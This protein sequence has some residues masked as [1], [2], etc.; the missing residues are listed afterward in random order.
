MEIILRDHV[1]NV[2]KRGD[3]VKV[4]NGYARN[5][6]LPRNLAL[7][8]TEANK[9]RIQR[10]RKIVE[11]RESEERVA[12]EALAERLVALDL[13]IARKVGDNDTLYG[14][15]TNSDIAELLKQK[16][17]DIDRRK[18]LLPDAIRALG[19]TLVPVKLHSD[20]TAQLKVAVVKE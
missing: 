7:P 19:E 11:A 2:G 6:L 20:V 12:A 16:G 4:A 15:V 13:Q 8:A 14:S 3:I 9:Q 18:I 17:F 10:E 1:D 5:Y